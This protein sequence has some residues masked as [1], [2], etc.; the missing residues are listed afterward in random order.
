M[1]KVG[2]VK[3]RRVIIQARAIVEDAFGGANPD[4]STVRTE[5][6]RY[7]PGTGAERRISGRE[8]SSHPATFTFRSSELTRTLAPN[9]H[10]LEFDGSYWDIISAVDDGRGRDIE[11]LATRIDEG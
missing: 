9:T 5:S 2:R 7:Y 11:V 4:W 10:R 3:D 1:R 6:A 8:V